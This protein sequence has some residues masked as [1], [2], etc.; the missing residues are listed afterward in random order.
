MKLFEVLIAPVTL[1]ILGLYV[2]LMLL[3]ALFP[4][5]KLPKVPNWKVKG[6][7]FFF[8]FLFLSSYLPF[9]YEKWL[10]TSRMVDLSQWN[11]L[12]AAAIGI[13]L[14]ELALWAWHRALHGSDLLW[15]G[16][17]QMHHSAERLDTFGA[18]YFSPLDTIGFTLLGT[19]CFSF[20]LGV[21]P[22][23][24]T[25]ILLVTNFLSILQH[26][27]IRT[28][29]WLGYIVQRPESHAVHHARGIHAF[30]YSDLPLIDMIFGTFRNPR[31]HVLDTGFHFGASSRMME[32]LRFKDVSI[33]NNLDHLPRTEVKPTSSD[34]V[35]GPRVS[36]R[37][38]QTSKKV[39]VFRD[40]TPRLVRKIGMYTIAA[41]LV[42]P[43][44]AQ[45]GLNTC[46]GIGGQVGQH[47]QDFGIGLNLTS[48]YFANKKMAVRL[49]GNVLWNEHLNGASEATWSSYS[50]LSLGFVQSVGEM[51]NFMRVYGEC[52]AIYLFPSEEFSS[53]S[54]VFGGY[55]LFGFEF[56]FDEHMNYFI[57]AGGVGTGARADEIPG[58]PIYSNGFL[59]N[60]GVRVQF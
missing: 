52:G 33:A 37:D 18:F 42:S 54:I 57:E 13:L 19:L 2:A 43:A 46:F 34:E 20:L 48:P 6:V 4:A 35:S 39:R 9:L 5:R 15:R 14:Y 31:S 36:A 26:A 45:D 47:Q 8:L 10:P 60:V 27:N 44:Q 12:L 17:H 1:V 59:I 28:P 38:Q 32:M 11:H 29:V 56:F 40:H 21:P 41:L 30:N 58:K 24:I 53:R 23:A 49:R 50:N 22:E 51:G 3:E 25:I 55:G 7:L 16:F